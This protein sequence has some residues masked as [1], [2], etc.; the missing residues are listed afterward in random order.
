ME[1]VVLPSLSQDGWVS[2]TKEKL[3]Y[4]MSHFFLSDYSQTFLYTGYVA[5]LSYILQANQNKMI[6]TK[7]AVINTLTDYLSRYKFTDVV[8]DVGI[9]EEEL[10][11]SR[12][13]M[14][15]YISVTDH[16]NKSHTFSSVI[17]TNDSKFSK[18]IQLNNEG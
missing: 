1:N 4:L 11:S 5:S 17:E 8:V 12:Q 7:N 13:I 3:D 2:S 16:E 9:K 10:N 15:I 14:S 18:V 6:D